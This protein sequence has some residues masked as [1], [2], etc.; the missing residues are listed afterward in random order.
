VHRDLPPCMGGEDFSFML[1]E[2]KGAYI[3]MGQAGGPSGCMV[4]NPRYD[5]NDEILAF[6]ASY[7]AK[8]VERLL[9]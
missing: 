9:A 6:G 1:N 4:H 2:C 8:L 7:W 3:W 5:F